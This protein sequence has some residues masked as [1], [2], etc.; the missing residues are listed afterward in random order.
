M[1]SRLLLLIG[2]VIFSQVAM[3][4]FRLGI[5]GGVNMTKIDGKSFS[6][7]FE[8]GYHLGGFAEIGLGKRFSIQPEVLFNQYN[9]RTDSSFKDI[10]QVGPETF[11]D[12]KLNYLAIPIMLN[13]KL[14]SLISLQAGPQFGILMSD[15]NNLLE[16]GKAA[17]T[18]G[19][20]ALAGGAQLN[21]SNFRISG[22]YF[23]G[24]NNISDIYDQEK[25][26]NQGLQLSVG[27]AF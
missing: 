13:Y 16:N 22:R 6:E 8:T 18:K 20:F 14:G 27:L 10:Y 4:Q 19:E 11:K 2:L 7:E 21:L 24:L 25:L 1:K 23:V 9:T 12:V 15:D 17:F 26:T 5:K 3:A